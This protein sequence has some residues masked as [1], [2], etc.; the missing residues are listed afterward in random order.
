MRIISLIIAISLLIAP[1]YSSDAFLSAKVKDISDRKYE[2]A[3]I[4]LLDNA[5]ESIVISMYT[6]NL[7]TTKNNPVTLLLNDLLEARQRD[8]SVTIYLNTRL[9]VAGKAKKYYI[10]NSTLKELEEAGCVIHLM[11]FKRMLHDKLVIVD[12]RYV[13][14]G[15]TNWSVS[16]LRKNLESAT[17]IDSPELA[18]IKLTRL[19]SLLMP[20]VQQEVKSYTPAYIEN[21]PKTLKVPKELIL[22]K[23]YLPRMTTKHSKRTMA[24]YFLLLA[25][26]Q[27]TG[28]KEFFISL[29]DMALS[30]R[31][32]LSWANNI[33]RQQVTTNLK[34]LQ[35]DYQLIKVQFFH[36]K[37]AAITLTDIPGKTVIM[38]TDSLIQ[39]K[40]TKLSTRLRFLLLIEAL[41]KDKGEDIHSISYTKLGKRFGLTH[42]TISK[43]FKDLKKFRG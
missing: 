9:W 2:E 15:S 13:V 23:K 17:L 41:L 16:A 34:E 40:D 37:D 27:V 33:L 30:L 32:P 10:N 19:K 39:T 21:L 25:H 12:S 26:S 7:G 38:P 22:N 24:I 28:K 14:E 8:V 35:N 4:E 29:E 43:A 11:G 42:S 36:G 31:M 1:A 6:I 20:S 5:K 18:K 3:V